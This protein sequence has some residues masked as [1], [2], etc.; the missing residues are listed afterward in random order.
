V[1]EKSLAA[2]WSEEVIKNVVY[3]VVQWLFRERGGR[4]G[5]LSEIGVTR[6]CLVCARLDGSDFGGI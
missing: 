2:K 5:G 4:V 1:R 3:V 6:L